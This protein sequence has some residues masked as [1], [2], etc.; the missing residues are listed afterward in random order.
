MDDRTG[1]I[2]VVAG[3]V[4]SAVGTVLAAMRARQIRREGRAYNYWQHRELRGKEAAGAARAFIAASVFWGFG[5]VVFLLLI[6]F[7]RP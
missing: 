2:V 6:I 5:T 4:F 7:A 3:T 1:F